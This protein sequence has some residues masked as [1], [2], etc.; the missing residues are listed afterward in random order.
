MMALRERELQDL[1]P[2]HGQI[3]EKDRYQM[4]M[5][6]IE[7]NPVTGAGTVSGI[8]STLTSATT[9]C[10]KDTREVVHEHHESIMLLE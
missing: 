8:V 9:N 3:G 10:R 6:P 2:K 4:N 7:G 1:L 5:V